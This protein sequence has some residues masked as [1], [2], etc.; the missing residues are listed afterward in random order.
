VRFAE[1]F[2]RLIADL[3]HSSWKISVKVNSHW[4]RQYIMYD[5]LEVAILMLI[6]QNYLK[7]IEDLGQEIRFT[8]L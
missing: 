7:V 5:E 1:R 3:S 4:Q 8:S 6:C 2:A